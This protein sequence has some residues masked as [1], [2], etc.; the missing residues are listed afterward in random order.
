MSKKIKNKK[1]FTLVELLV[2][3]IIIGVLSAIA[4]PQYF[5]ALD[6]ARFVQVQTFVESLVRAEESYFL[7]NGE[8]TTN[9]NALDVDIPNIKE[10][11]CR[12]YQS[13]PPSPICYLYKNNKRF[14]SLQ[15]FPQSR[16]EFCMSYSDTNFAGD[17]LCMSAMNTSTTYYENTERREYK[18]PYK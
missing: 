4:L 9:I 11:K 15:I 16:R 10:S 14:V 13:T 3:V 2:V 6:K 8:Y 7:L 18:K 1:G 12:I 5:K 17:E